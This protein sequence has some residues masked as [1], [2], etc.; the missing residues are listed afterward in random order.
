MG[1]NS[2]PQTQFR[3]L[4]MHF[5]GRF[6]DSEAIAAPHTDMHL[7]FVQILGL[8]VVPGLLKTYLSLA[9]YSALAHGPLSV[10]E[11]AELVDQYFFLCVSM[12]LIGFITV[13]EWDTLFPDH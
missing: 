3:R 9:S 13:F 5:F 8:L 11:H 1:D 4:A 2:L 12:L 10:R 6:F 7:L